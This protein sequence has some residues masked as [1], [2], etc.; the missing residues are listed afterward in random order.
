[1]KSD[2]IIARTFH[3]GHRGV[4]SGCGVGPNF[5][6][7]SSRGASI[8][9]RP[10]PKPPRIVCVLF[11]SDVSSETS[12]GFRKAYAKKVGSGQPNGTFSSFL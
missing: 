4:A 1:M 7:E 10:M 3:S 8:I 5:I 12:R 2:R 6:R 9:K 11:F